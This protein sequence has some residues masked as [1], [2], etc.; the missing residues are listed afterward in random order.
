MKLPIIHRHSALFKDALYRNSD[1]CVTRYGSVISQASLG[2]NTRLAGLW[3]LLCLRTCWCNSAM[4]V[5]ACPLH[6]FWST[7]TPALA[8]F[9]TIGR[10]YRS[11]LHL[12]NTATILESKLANA[13]LDLRVI[14]FTK[15]IFGGSHSFCFESISHIVKV[16]PKRIKFI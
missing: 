7:I 12:N 4:G 6:S 16:W 15:T 13:A 14:H 11:Q 9:L 1:D 2:F 10:L 3:P 8:Q 5:Q